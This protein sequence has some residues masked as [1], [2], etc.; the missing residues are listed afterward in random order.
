ME[1]IGDNTCI[2]SIRPKS[3]VV[4]CRG[5]PHKY[6]LELQFV[7]ENN[8]PVTGLNVQ[9]EYHP[10]ASAKEVAI[11]HRRGYDYDPTPPPNPPTGVTDSQGLV[12][13]D[14]LYWITVDVKVDGQQLAD[15]MEQRP[16]GLRR[17]PNSQP[18]TNNIF[19]PET[20]DPSWRTDVQEKA[21]ASGYTHH[22]VTIG[23][24]CDR[25]PHIEGWDAPEPPKFH[26]PP[27]K[28]LKGTEIAR[29]ALEQRH[30]I[31]ICP[32]R[33]WVLALHDTKDYDLANALN[34]G[35]MADL[36]YA[37][38]TKNPTI[39]YF[40]RQKCLDLSCIP[41]FAEFPSYFHTLAVDVPFRERYQPPVYMNTGAGDAG[42]GDTR[43]FTVECA[44]HVLVAWCGTD[45][46]LNVLTDLS[47]APKRCLP[48]LAGA[49]SVHG[50]FL[51][52]YQL[53]KRKFRDKLDAVKNDL[54]NRKTL[55]VCGHSL[56]GALALLYSAEMK[57][58]NPVL[59]TYGM[60]RTFTRAAIAL[61]DGI[62]HYRHVNDN[63]TITQIPPDADLDNAFY[64]TWGPL[65]TKLGFD[66]SLTTAAGFSVAV[67][68][69]TYQ[70]AGLTE[71]KDPYW[72]HG[73]TVIFFQAQQC[74]MR[75]ASPYQKSLVDGQAYTRHF[76]AIKLYVVPS[77]NEECLKSTGK[78]QAAFI[79]CLDPASLKKTFPQNT[80]PTLNGIGTDPR[81]HSMAHRYLPYIHNQ[82][83]ELADPAQD[84]SRKVMR[85]RFRDEV[86]KSAPGSNSNEVGRNREFL[87]LQDML[88]VALSRTRAEET[89]K[90]AL[91]RFAEVTDEDVEFS[92]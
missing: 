71:K 51:E 31:E 40:F 50:G 5:E 59:Y 13:F 85:E 47:F 55:F 78:H 39:D 27:G 34:L 73:N 4:Y 65:G 83:L 25:L 60:P 82:V 8:H 53:A 1:I 56:G 48:E 81:S 92:Q 11:A 86:E 63:D 28:S 77:L 66:W 6:W 42:E 9:L 24:L 17:N 80:N 58:F 72:H 89:G 61:L 43:L 32:F 57:A 67:R 15:G 21:E 33:A 3:K 29:E 22:Y 90:N 14:D 79:E 74:A 68:D 7:D 69:L 46:L 16:L 76:V 36:V 30:M 88:S 12:R 62:T 91:L 64:K 52:A 38:E 10:L 26:F 23:E 49:G 84:M 19:R 2:T 54:G 20:R 44:A 87:A 41:Q 70:S 75:A 45:S 37:A 35:I 18:V